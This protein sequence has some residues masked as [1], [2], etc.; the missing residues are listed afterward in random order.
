MVVAPGVWPM[1]TEGR[2]HTTGASS[3][4]WWHGDIGRAAY[5][6]V[7]VTCVPSYKGAAD[8]EKWGKQ[9][10]HPICGSWLC[11]WERS[12]CATAQAFQADLSGFYTPA[13]RSCAQTVM[14]RRLL[15]VGVIL[16]QCGCPLAH[17]SRGSDVNA[18]EFL[19]CALPADIMAS[20]RVQDGRL[21]TRWHRR[22]PSP[23]S[24]TN[25]CQSQPF[26]RPRTPFKCHVPLLC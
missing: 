6:G 26:G 19:G 14:Q 4:P 15:L 22:T 24:L 25:E 1:L 8:P 9:V 13:A 2:R 3:T 23:S 21:V 18:Q 20:V 5:G 12:S 11:T 10:T 7:H 17:P 16:L